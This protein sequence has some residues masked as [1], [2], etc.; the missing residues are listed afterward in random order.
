MTYTFKHSYLHSI[1]KL[2]K[3]RRITINKAIETLINFFQT[4]EIP[5]GLGLK[6]LRYNFWEIR[7]GLF[8]RIIFRRISDKIE[9]IIAGSH[10]EIKRF[11][12][13]I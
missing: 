8:E 12:K 7:A 1:K 6:Q 9:F 11:L 3:K 13:N 5:K 4:R 10:D 2:D